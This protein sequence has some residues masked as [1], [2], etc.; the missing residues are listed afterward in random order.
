MRE[1]L[2]FKWSN[3][4][5]VEQFSVKFGENIHRSIHVDKEQKG[6]GKFFS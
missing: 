6:A 3:T 4:G 5:Y 1:S 2:L